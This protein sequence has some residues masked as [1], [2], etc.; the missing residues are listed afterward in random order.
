MRRFRE[1][2]PHRDRVHDVVEREESVEVGQG[3][4][5]A[6]AKPEDEDREQGFEGQE[7]AARAGLPFQFGEVALAVRF[8]LVAGRDEEK[9]GGR[10]R[11][12]GRT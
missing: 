3:E 6:A 5:V 2:R 12:R 10:G 4:A 11:L 8:V 9:A 1:Q 7:T